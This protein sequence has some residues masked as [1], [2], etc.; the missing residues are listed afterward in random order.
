MVVST[1]FNGLPW[2]AAA[3]RRFGLDQARSVTKRRQAAALQSSF[4]GLR[5]N[6][7]V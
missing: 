5:V 4:F 2:S 6:W 1:S 3:W 7:N